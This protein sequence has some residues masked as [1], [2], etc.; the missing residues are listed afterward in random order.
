MDKRLIAVV[1]VVVVALAAAGAYAVFSGDG[2]GNGTIVGK[3]LKE[4]EFPSKDSRLWVYG[5]A[6]EDDKL[7]TDDVTYLQSVVDG[8]KDSTT[9]CDA[10]A[11][12]RIDGED[13]D[14]LRTIIAAIGTENALDVFYVDNYF[15]VAKVSC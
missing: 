8:T 9:L 4:N 10:N 6:N 11:D 14:Y 5:N 13:L 3:Q 15:K 1:A 12:G 2:S 7:D